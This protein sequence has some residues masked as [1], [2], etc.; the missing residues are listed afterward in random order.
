[1]AR[2]KLAVIDDRHGFYRICWYL[3]EEDDLG[4]ELGEQ[5]YTQASLDKAGPSDRDHILASLTA[6]KTAGVERDRSYYWESH[7][8]ATKA[9]RLINVTLKADGGAPWPD[10]AIKAK[11]EGW[12]APKGWKP[13]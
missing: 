12:K 6:K 2:D 7:A 8:A 11:A 3:A 13:S 1:M 5:E 9:L 4:A 10:W